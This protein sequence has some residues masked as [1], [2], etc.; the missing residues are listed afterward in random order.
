MAG[1]VNL[2]QWRKQ[3]SRSEAEDKAAQNRAKFGQTKSAKEIQNVS[4]RQSARHLDQ[5]SLKTEPEGSA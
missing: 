5:H 3:K 2:R 1:T 4:K